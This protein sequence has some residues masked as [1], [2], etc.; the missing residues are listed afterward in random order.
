MRRVKGIYG[1]ENSAHHFFRDF[2]YCDS[3]M[4]PWL[5]VCAIM[6]EKG[7]RLG[8][9]VAEMEK[10]FPCSGEIN[11]PAK[12]VAA[13]LSAVKETYASTASRV[14][15][16]DGV[17]LEFENWRFNLRPSN[18]EPLIRFNMETKGDKALLL[19]KEKEIMALVEKVNG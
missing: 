15:P 14:D 4:I 17:G 5:I 8:E 2:S 18:T 10:E 9:L 12:N 16:I 19:E 13:T 6:S 11:L 1:A 3:G 7:K